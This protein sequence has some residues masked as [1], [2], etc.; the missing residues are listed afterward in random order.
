MYFFDTSVCVCVFFFNFM[1]FIEENMYSL[2][3]ISLNT[4]HNKELI[5][6]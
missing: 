2:I 6:N 1:L 3:A 4:K 5:E